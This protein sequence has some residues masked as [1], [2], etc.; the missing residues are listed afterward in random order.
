MTLTA[1]SSAGAIVTIV[2]ASAAMVFDLRVR[3]IPNAITFPAIGVGVLLWSLSTGWTGALA[4]GIGAAVCPLLLVL[5]HGGRRPG[6]G[7]LKLAA[8]IGSLL[9]PVA[10]AVAILVSAILGGLVAIVWAFRP[11]TPA[12]ETLGVLFLGVPLL[13]RLAGSRRAENQTGDPARLRFPYGVAIGLG[14]IATAAAV[15]WR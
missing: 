9:G 8:A 2:V 14:S 1:H 6:M 7:D 5:L 12:R 3:R 4:A 15:T 11:G 10:G 13:G